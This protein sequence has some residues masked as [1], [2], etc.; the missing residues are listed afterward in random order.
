VKVILGNNVL[1]RH[2]C[3]AV[4]IILW[5]SGVVAVLSLSNERGISYESR[6][7]TFRSLVCQSRSADAIE[8]TIN[9]IERGAWDRR[10]APACSL[11]RARNGAGAY[12]TAVDMWIAHG[13]AIVA[14]R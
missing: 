7:G 6:H 1:V 13:G 12:P 4:K 10:P 11:G 14:I 3:E 2:G 5:P 9:F 8:V